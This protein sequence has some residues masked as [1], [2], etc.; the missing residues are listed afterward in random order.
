MP[1]PSPLLIG[2]KEYL[3]LPDLNVF[4]LKAKVDTG[5]RTSTLHVDAVT[6]LGGSGGEDLLDL[7]LG[8]D[9]RSPSHSLHARARRLDIV[10]V[11][12]SSGS[13]ELRPLIETTLVLGPVR[14]TI[15][16]TLTNRSAMLFRMLLGRTAIAGDFQID[17]ALKYVLSGYHAEQVGA[18]S[19]HR[20]RRSGKPR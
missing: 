5:A 8:P 7:N 17:V 19:R 20:A 2:W 14:K 15:Q 10:S 12:D 9:P 16:L 13:P 18:A 3:D 4:G 6:V 11:T 1:R